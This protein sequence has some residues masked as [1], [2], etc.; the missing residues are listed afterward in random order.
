MPT[1]PIQLDRS[2]IDVLFFSFLFL[3]MFELVFFA[4]GVVGTV[5]ASITDLKTTE[6][7]DQIPYMMMAVGIIFFSIESILTSNY[8]LIEKS[9]L[10]GLSF[11]GFG[12]LMYYLG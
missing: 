6:I 2:F 7:P 12:F 5:L 10:A 4:V 9:F 3:N 1:W 8:L 11:L